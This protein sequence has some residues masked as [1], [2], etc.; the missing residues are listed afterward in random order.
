MDAHIGPGTG[1]LENL[2]EGREN[3]GLDRPDAAQAQHLPLLQGSP[4]PLVQ[5]HERLPGIG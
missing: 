4:D 1:P 3:I 2:E 5:L